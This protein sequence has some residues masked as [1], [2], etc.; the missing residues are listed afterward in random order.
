[1]ARPKN[2][3][4]RRAILEASIGLIAEHGL[5]ASTAVIAKQAGVAHGSLFSHFETKGDLINA[6]YLVL[7]SELNEAVLHDLPKTSN[8]RQRFHHLWSQWID[9]GSSQPL[10]RRALAQL[11]VSD[12]ITEKSKA[13]SFERA[14]VGISI[15]REVTDLGV[16]KDQPIEFV[17]S[18]IDAF[19][20]ATIDAVIRNPKQASTYRECAFEALWKALK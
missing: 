18:L 7:K 1:M 19:V 16:L 5:N 3:E 15:V 13:A 8:A 11:S 4:M 6:V 14:A 2:A 9:W 17:G 12:Q 20:G 10:R